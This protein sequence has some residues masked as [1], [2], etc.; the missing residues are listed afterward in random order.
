MAEF[1]DRYQRSGQDPV[2][3]AEIR[4]LWQRAKEEAGGLSEL[5]KA[6][7]LV[8]WA[9]SLARDIEEFD[10]KSP[11]LRRIISE[12]KCL[13]VSVRKRGAKEPIPE[14]ELAEIV[15]LRPY[16]AYA[17]RRYSRLR[18]LRRF[19]DHCFDPV[20]LKTGKDLLALA[21]FLNSLV[22]YVQS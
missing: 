12:M 5:A 9:R 8:N 22:A 17:A 4:K 11:Q 6:E 7:D 1:Q 10:L 20:M 18:V 3:I 14:A 19:L 21:K 15:F 16:M 13:E 2:A